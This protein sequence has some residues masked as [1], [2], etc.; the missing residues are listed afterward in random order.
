MMRKI[1]KMISVFLITLL[2]MISS[3]VTFGAYGCGWT[4]EVYSSELNSAVNYASARREPRNH[5]QCVYPSFIGAYTGMPK[6]YNY[7]LCTNHDSANSHLN[8]IRIVARYYNPNAKGKK[9]SGTIN[10]SEGWQKGG[11]FGWDIT[12]S[13]S[14]LGASVKSEQN[15]SYAQNFSTS[16]NFNEPV[17]PK[18]TGKIIAYSLGKFNGGQTT[19]YGLFVPVGSGTYYVAQTRS[20]GY[21]YA[22]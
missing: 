8:N 4:G 1:A 6:F 18:K 11:S 17:G 12:A 19:K 7:G 3:V 9:M 21:F 5:W 10:I 14:G 13:Y 22:Q 16:L 15:W 20:I 2:L